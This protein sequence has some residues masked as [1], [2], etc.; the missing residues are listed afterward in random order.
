MFEL[1][2]GDILVFKGAGP[3]WWIL[4]RLLR[5]FEGWWDSWGWHMAYVSRINREGQVW[6]TEGTWPVSREVLLDEK[7]EY[8]VYR[9]LPQPVDV[10][11]LRQF[12]LD[13]LGKRYD[14]AIYFLTSCQYLFRHFLNRPIP[15]LLDD[16][17]TCWELCE[18]LTAF[19]GILWGSRYDCPMITDFLEW[20]EELLITEAADAAVRLQKSV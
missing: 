1:M 18:E 14:V 19:F 10:I 11:K 12:T 3:A 8:R 2:P 5:I 7:R 13:H 9:V 17:Y 4:S 16:R 20:A 6:I 15:R